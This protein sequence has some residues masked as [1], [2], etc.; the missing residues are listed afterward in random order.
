MTEIKLFNQSH[1]SS[2]QNDI[3]TP[4][5]DVSS[6]VEICPCPES[7]H[8]CRQCIPLSW[9]Q[10][11]FDG[12]IIT[13]GRRGVSKILVS[14]IRYIHLMTQFSHDWC[15]PCW[16]Y[17][18]ACP[19]VSSILKQFPISSYPRRTTVIWLA[20][21]YDCISYNRLFPLRSMALHQVAIAYRY[22][23]GTPPGLSMTHN[24]VT[25]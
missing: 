25:I 3:C 10:S 20:Q 1:V 19:L 24:D 15:L 9:H 23:S 5:S 17:T 22:P 8:C 7:T 21:F 11:V 13:S 16:Q 18:E 2:I 14:L 6:P 12:W 4:V